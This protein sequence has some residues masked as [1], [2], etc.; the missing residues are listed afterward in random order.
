MNV[1]AADFEESIGDRL[2]LDQLDSVHAVVVDI[3][4]L[5]DDI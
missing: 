5:D 3:V 1:V 4:P 2:D